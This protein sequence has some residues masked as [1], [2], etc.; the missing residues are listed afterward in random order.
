MTNTTATDQYHVHQLSFTE[1][2]STTPTEGK[3]YATERGWCRDCNTEI[4]RPIPYGQCSAECRNPFTP[5]DE[6]LG[7]VLTAVSLASGEELVPG[8]KIRDTGGR[9]YTYLYPTAASARAGF[10][11]VMLHVNGETYERYADTIGARVYLT[12]GMDHINAV[13]EDEPTPVGPLCSA[14]YDGEGECTH[15]TCWEICHMSEGPAWL[16]GATPTPTP[17]FRWAGCEYCTRYDRACGRHDITEEEFKRQ[18]QAKQYRELAEAIAAQ[19]EAIAKGT[20]TGP[21]YGAVR[22]LKGNVEILAA[23]TED[24]RS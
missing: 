15:S 10:G 16:Y 8:A 13:R 6:P 23:W 20:I 7:W 12:G 11:R 24:D 3:P 2:V 14:Q 5:I 19:A 4:H 9:E 21:H 17:S 22:M 18:R 1:Y